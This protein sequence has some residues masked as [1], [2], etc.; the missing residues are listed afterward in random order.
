MNNLIAS[1]WSGHD[2]NYAVLDETG[3][4]LVHAEHERYSRIRTSR[5]DSVQFLFDTFPEY[6]KIKYFGIVYPTNKI[7]EYRESYDKLSKII[8]KNDGLIFNIGHHNAHASAVYYSSNFEE[9]LIITVDGGGVEKNFETACAFWYGKDNNV[10]LLKSYPINQVNIGGLWSRTTRYIWKKANGGIGEPSG[11]G[12]V[13]CLPAFSKNP[14]RFVEDFK[15]MLTTDLIIASEKPSG[16]PSKFEIGKDPIHPY[17]NKYVKMAEDREVSYDLAAGLQKATEW[18][19]KLLI[20]EAIKLYPGKLKNIC[21]CGGV[22][23][24]SCAMGK[25]FDWFPEYKIYINSCVHDGGLSL[26]AALSIAYEGNSEIKRTKVGTPYLGHFSTKEE[27]ESTLEEYKEK[28]NWKIV[29]DDQVVDLLMQNKIVAVHGGHAESGK[30]ALFC[31]SILG[32]PILKGNQDYIS[33][34]IKGRESER[35]LAPGILRE[36][37]SNWFEKDIDAP[38]MS[39]VIPFKKDKIDLVPA[40]VHKDGT[41]RLQTITEENNFWAYHFLKKWKEKSGVP[42]LI[43][44][45]YNENEP[46]TNTAKHSIECFLRTK[47]DCLYFYDYGIL[48]YRE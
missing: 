13:M 3:N 11:E 42:I 9:S 40:C 46:I 28:I 7:T 15:K 19:L 16:Q 35:P 24:N 39:Y 17:L 45:S 21:L 10:S 37:V 43:N 14:E 6:E 44:T 26:G 38:Y 31:R 32:S 27:V 29:D 30:R 36:E 34:T 12:T 18:Q 20:K 8:Q 47:I 33:V 1:S 23:L 25:L 22:T 4:I 48:V 5:T 41:G 2:S